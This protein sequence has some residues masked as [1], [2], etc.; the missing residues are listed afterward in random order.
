MCAALLIWPAVRHRWQTWWLAH[1][2]LLAAFIAGNSYWSKAYGELW[3]RTYFTRDASRQLAAALPADAVV[4]GRRTSTL[5]RNVPVRLGMCVQY[6]PDEFMKRIASLLADH[7]V[8]WLV[9]GD[10]DSQWKQCRD[11]V[12]KWWRISYVTTVQIPSGDLLHIR[13]VE[14]QFPMVPVHLMRIGG[15]A[16]TSTATAPAS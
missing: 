13:E 16:K 2:F 11:A 5:L 12:R 3:A 10:E 9:D 7:P 4:I 14:E 6:E 15:A 8:F 1:V